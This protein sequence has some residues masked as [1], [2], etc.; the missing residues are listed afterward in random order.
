[1]RDPLGPYNQFRLSGAARLPFSRYSGAQAV[2]QRNLPTDGRGIFR[3]RM[4]G[5]TE[6]SGFVD[7]R[8]HVVLEVSNRLTS[9]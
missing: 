4:A 5:E 9:T 8:F 2:R 1:M 3:S 6:F 7:L